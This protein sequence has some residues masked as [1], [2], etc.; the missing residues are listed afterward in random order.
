MKSWEYRAVIYNGQ[1]LCVS[2]VPSDAQSEDIAPIFASEELE[3]YP[4]CAVC[5]E[6]HIYPKISLKPGMI[7]N[8]DAFDA[9]N[10]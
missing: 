7:N 2:C 3:E 9:V 10:W 1:A 6:V 4:I 5:A 8:E